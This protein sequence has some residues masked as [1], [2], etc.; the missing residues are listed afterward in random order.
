VAQAFVALAVG[1]PVALLA[2]SMLGEP[3]LRSGLLAAG[4]WVAAVA[5]VT[6]TR[7]LRRRPA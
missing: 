7:R 2:G 3:R 5:L 4:A 1:T 6:L